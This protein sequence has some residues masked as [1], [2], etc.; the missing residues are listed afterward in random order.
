MNIMC[1]EKSDA[2]FQYKPIEFTL[3]PM[4]GIFLSLEKHQQYVA[5]KMFEA[6][7]HEVRIKMVY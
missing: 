5:G 1:T 3:V 6:N 2:D 7:G 4:V